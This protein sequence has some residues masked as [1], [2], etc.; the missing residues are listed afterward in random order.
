MTAPDSLP[1]AAP[2]AWE[3]SAL[4]LAVADA[5]RYRLGE[6]RVQGELAGLTRAASGHWYFALKDEQ[7]Q[8]RCAMFRRAASRVAF[9]PNDGAT[10]EVRGRLDVYAPRGDL[11][12]IVE[13]MRP[14]GQGLWMQRYEA[15][16][17][18]LQAEGL[19]DSERK[20]PIASLP[21]RVAVV[22]SLEAAALQDVLSALQR[23]APHVP[24]TVVPALV[25]GERAP[26]Q[27]VAALQRAARV[28]GVQTV[29]LVRGGGAVEDLWAFNDERVV[30]TVAGLECP[31]ICGVGHE[32]DVT[33][34]DFAADVRA[35]TPTA[36]AELCATPLAQLRAHWQQQAQALAQG[37]DRWLRHRQ[38]ALD[39]MGQ[40]HQGAVAQGLQRQR[41][42][43]DLCQA[44]LHAVH[45]QRVLQRGFALLQD[46]QGRVI[47]RASA[48][49]TGDSVVA[50][51][52]DGRLNLRVDD[53]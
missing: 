50:T 4:M 35:P 44:T 14:T 23:R 18:K 1:N 40:R 33:L 39:H 34:C 21:L 24:V 41:Q 48:V 30:R 20:R 28:P 32:T 6:V 9:H 13:D 37:L 42:R 2:T 31:V 10:V 8:V 27:L 45:P 19:F 15:L 11:Q 5:V 38:Q 12:L 7:A 53:D 3:V 43:L 29:L 16:K 25:Q 47:E 49:F 46:A 22:T 26:G 17:A 51:L 52:A 36:A